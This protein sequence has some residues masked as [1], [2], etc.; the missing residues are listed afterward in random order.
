MLGVT[1]YGGDAVTSQTDAGGGSGGGG[2]GGALGGLIARRLQQMDEDRA[3][4]LRQRQIQEAQAT[5]AR[6]KPTV[7]LGRNPGRSSSQP[8]ASAEGGGSGGGGGR[9]AEAPEQQAVYYKMRGGPN[10]V[11]GY[12]EVAAGSPGA[13]FSGYRD[14]RDAPGKTTFANQASDAVGGTRAA[15][16]PPVADPVGSQ[17]GARG[18]GDATDRWYELPSW[19][20]TQILARQAAGDGD[21]MPMGRR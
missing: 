18:G 20:R 6:M 2:V 3:Y 21:A 17:A 9:R 10:S 4:E 1:N 15:Y 12:T 13:V 8:I 5:K 7:G 14:R 11:A 16:G 19:Y